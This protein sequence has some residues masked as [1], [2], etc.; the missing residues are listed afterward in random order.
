MKKLTICSPHYTPTVLSTLLTNT[1]LSNLQDGL[2]HTSLGDIS[3][4]NLLSVCKIV[5]EIE[6][7]D[8]N[9]TDHNTYIKTLSILNQISKSKP[10]NN[11][12]LNPPTSFL[13]FTT[14]T[15]AVS[16]W[17]FGCSFSHGVGVSTNERF[18]NII[19]NSINLPLM[20]ITNP[21]SS[22]RW[23]LRQ[24]INTNFKKDDLVIWQISTFSRLSIATDKDHLK[25]Y[26]IKDT[27]KDTIMNTSKIQLYVDQLSLLNYGIQ[28]LRAKQ[29][30][31]VVISLDNQHSFTD[32]LIYEYSLYPEYLY[33]GEWFVDKGSDGVHPGR[34]SHKL[35][36]ES[37]HNVIQ[38]TD[39]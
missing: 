19:S 18:S 12:K 4:N 10:I 21:G 28:Y 26:L 16:L 24:L 11:F 29:V 35:V 9:D 2:Y 33:M 23:G 7:I 36:A 22:T 1:N 3:I 39:E 34:L 13:E 5:D 8:F 20:D 17:V 6:F 25:E 30:K 32:D 31:F 15:D 38:Y 37:I 14:E 27:N